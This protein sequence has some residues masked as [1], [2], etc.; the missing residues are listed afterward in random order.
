MTALEPDVELA[1]RLSHRVSQ[2]FDPVRIVIGTTLVEVRY[3]DSA[4][5]C[6]SAGNRVL[7]RSSSPTVAQV[8]LWDRC[9]IPC[10]R[11]I[12]RL[13]GNRVGKSILAVWRRGAV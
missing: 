12:D 4:G 3:L 6:L 7:L 5:L 8:M 10:S 13:L 2:L 11:R 9:C 1:L